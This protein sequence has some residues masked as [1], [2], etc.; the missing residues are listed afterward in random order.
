MSEPLWLKILAGTC[1]GLALTLIVR[2]L[3]YMRSV[4]VCGRCRNYLDH[5]TCPREC[6][7]CGALIVQNA[8][9]SHLLP[10]GLPQ[11]LPGEWLGRD[12]AAWAEPCGTFGPQNGPLARP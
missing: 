7:E 10:L 12:R 11:D 8:K 1:G 5:C 6:P 4:A 3:V 2:R 9:L